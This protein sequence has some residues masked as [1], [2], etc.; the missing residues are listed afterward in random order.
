MN[1]HDPLSRNPLL[2]PYFFIFFCGRHWRG[3]PL[4]S[5]NKQNGPSFCS[6][7]WSAFNFIFDCQKASTLGK[8]EVPC[9]LTTSYRD[10][11]VYFW[12]GTFSK[13]DISKDHEKGVENIW[14]NHRRKKGDIK[15]YYMILDIWHWILMNVACFL[16]NKN[17]QT[18]WRKLRKLGSS[19]VVTNNWS[20][21]RTQPKSEVSYWSTLSPWCG[22]FTWVKVSKQ[23]T[24]EVNV[25]HTW[26][27]YVIFDTL[28]WSNVVPS[29]SY[30]T[31]KSINEKFKNW[32]LIHEVLK[33]DP[34]EVQQWS[35]NFTIP[36]SLQKKFASSG[37]WSLPYKSWTE[38]LLILKFNLYYKSWSIPCLKSALNEVESRAASKEIEV[39]FTSSCKKLKLKF[40]PTQI[41]SNEV[42]PS[43]KPFSHASSTIS[44]SQPCT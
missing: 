5:H 25:T 17:P 31:T 11:N 2:K 34:V 10:T 36:G 7:A 26:E 40:H 35:R 23:Y 9:G 14:N 4:D 13:I 27:V 33:H 28:P 38:V 44:R 37:N 30:F 19:E 15:L 22:L 43:K 3:A 8:V 18:T 29:R 20:P 24:S 41:K 32:S 21:N 16:P 42:I 39:E 12:V 1:H 6:P